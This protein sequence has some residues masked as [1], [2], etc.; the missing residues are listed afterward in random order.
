M[1]LEIILVLGILIGYLN[2]R[3]NTLADRAFHGNYFINISKFEFVNKFIILLG[4]VSM[5]ST[6]AI[7]VWG[8]VYLKWYYPLATLIV[9]IVLSQNN[10]LGK[11]M[12]FKDMTH[13]IFYIFIVFANSYLWIVKLIS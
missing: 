2:A 5:I 1:I 11:I 12:P 10:Y 13:V 9:S 3:S 4:F 6:F 7:I 8:F